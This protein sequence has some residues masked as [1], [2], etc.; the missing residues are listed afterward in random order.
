MPAPVSRLVR[1]GALASLIPLALAGCSKNHGE[2]VVDDTVGVT[3]LRTACP[4]IGIPEMTGDVTLL[5]PGRQDSR[6]ID[7]VATITNVRQSCDNAARLPKVTSQVEFDVLARRSDTHGARHL[8]LPYFSVV[9]RGGATIVAKHVATIGIDFADGQD[10]ASAHGSASAVI[11][12]DAASLPPAIRARL[13]RKRKAGDTD[14]AVDPLSL[15]E[16]K[17]ALAKAT[18][19]LLVGFQLTEAQLAYNARR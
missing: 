5:A 3:A 18:F 6:A 9:E 4:L 7:V 13:I 15:P 2:L 17:A 1:I 10:R 16:V 11:D 12:R 19:E 14:A 8:D